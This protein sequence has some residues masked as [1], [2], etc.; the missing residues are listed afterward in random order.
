MRRTAVDRLN[1][2]GLQTPV[3]KEIAELIRG[4]LLDELFSLVNALAFL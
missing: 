1:E 4:T 2:V 3:A